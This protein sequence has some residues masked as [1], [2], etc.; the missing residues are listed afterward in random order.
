MYNYPCEYCDGLVRPKQIEQEAFKHRDGF[1]IMKNII[2][3]VCDKCGNRYYNADIL[4][5]VEAI[6]TG[7]ATADAEERVP[8]GH[9]T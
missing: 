1:V 5:Q 8:V 7:Q 3:G 9:L 2:I 6:A 4:R